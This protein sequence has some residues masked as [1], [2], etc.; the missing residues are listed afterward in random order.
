MIK[1]SLVLATINRVR[2]VDRFLQSLAR[3][4]YKNFELIVVDQNDDD[5][6]SSL[7]DSYR[8]EFPI[9][10]LCSAR[11]LSVARNVGLG[12]V[13]GDLVAFPDDDC[14]YPEH[15]LRNVALIFDKNDMDILSGQSRD[16]HNRQSQRY[17]PHKPYLADKINIWKLAISY[18]VFIRRYCVECLDG[19][20]ETLGVGASS[21]WQSGEE[22]DYLIR[23]M[24]LGYKIYYDPQIRVFHPQ[25]TGKFGEEEK[26]RARAYGAGLGRVLKKQD[27]PL[28]FVGYMLTRPIGGIIASL[29]ILRFNKAMYHYRV[30]QGR[31]EGWLA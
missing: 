5:R 11:G 8:D 14:W 6:V 29:M 30:L 18:T 21:P 24:S 19:F 25:K 20:D 2:E 1:F 9:T 27:Y 31:L 17:W 13:T 7:V 3:Q 23:A 12:H 16:A 10:Y 15:L 26:K 4:T 28:W 22:T